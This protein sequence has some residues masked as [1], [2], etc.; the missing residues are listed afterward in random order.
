[1][2]SPSQS[3][4][5]DARTAILNATIKVLETSG[6]AS[7]RLASIAEDAG[8]AIG[9]IGYHFG[10]REGLIEAAQ[11]ERYSE[12]TVADLGAVEA[13]IAAAK[14]PDDFL[15]LLAAFTS[16][17]VAQ[18]TREGSRMRRVALL[19]SAFGRPELLAHY[20]EVQRDLT[21]Q[22][23][24]AARTAQDNGLLRS[25][26]DPRAIAVFTQAYALGMVLADID[27]NGPDVEAMSQ[28]ILA[29][30]SGLVPTPD[31]G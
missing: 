22:Y 27:P 26:L 2:G 30:M 20:G 9:L 4:R 19:G 6:E 12:R 8:V 3:T 1:M 21:D 11:A 13:G 24:R 17:A 31:P 18:A 14:D 15:G 7:V 25:D 23:E 5:V 10:G 16:Q 29:A 28:V